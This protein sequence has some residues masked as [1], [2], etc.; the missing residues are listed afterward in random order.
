MSY[1]PPL[2]SPFSTAADMFEIAIAALLWR[3]RRRRFTRI[4]GVLF[5]FRFQLDNTRLQ[6]I[7]HSPQFGYRS[8]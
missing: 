3:V 7:D 5:Q 8:L 6:F 4:G 2:R 1:V